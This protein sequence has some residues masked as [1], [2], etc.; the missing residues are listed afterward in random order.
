MDLVL[1]RASEQTGEDFGS[2]G[3]YTDVWGFATTLLH[4]ATGQLPYNGLTPYQILTAMIKSRPPAV[5]E[6]LPVWLQ[7][8]PKQCMSFD[9]AARPAVPHLLQ[10]NVP[11]C[12]SLE[13]SSNSF[14]FIY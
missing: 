13:R 3:S 1:R 6:T 14:H 9:V 7:R 5:P 11:P 10:V 4:L 12:A 8:L 2:R